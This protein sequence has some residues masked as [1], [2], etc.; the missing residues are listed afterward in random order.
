MI[1]L[2]LTTMPQPPPDP[3][4]AFIDCLRAEG[5]HLVVR[6]ASWALTWAGFEAELLIAVRGEWRY[7]VPLSKRWGWRCQSA[8]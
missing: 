2:Y 3:V 5:C 4:L 8:N 6:P 7:A 1:P